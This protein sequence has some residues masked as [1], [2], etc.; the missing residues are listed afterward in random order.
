MKD[1]ITIKYRK[2][3]N[4]FSVKLNSYLR[5]L[6]QSQPLTPFLSFLMLLF[7]S[8][9]PSFSSFLFIWVFV[10][11]SRVGRFSPTRNNNS[12]SWSTILEH[13]HGL[14]FPYGDSTHVVHQNIPL[15][16]VVNVI[17]LFDVKVTL[18][19]RIFSKIQ[20]S[21]FIWSAGRN[22]LTKSHKQE[23]KQVVNRWAAPR[24]YSQALHRT[25]IR[26]YN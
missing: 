18:G 11:P 12:S 23:V 25:W 9:S 20:T 5:I 3:Y 22:L 10:F 24:L 4:R 17:A 26:A 19:I 16:S 2:P 15:K 14:D 1:I 7:S 13:W 8:S 6:S 21:N